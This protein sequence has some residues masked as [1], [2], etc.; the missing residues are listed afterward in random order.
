MAK[1]LRDCLRLFVAVGAAALLGLLPHVGHAQ[2]FSWSLSADQSASQFNN[3]DAPP[4]TGLDSQGNFWY[5]YSDC[6]GHPHWH[7]CK[8]TSMDNLVEQYSFDTSAFARPNGDD[9]YWI[10][11]MWIDPDT[12]TWWAVAHVE[13]D[14]DKWGYNTGWKDHFR[15]IVL[16]SS[17]NHGQTWT[18]GGDIITPNPAA[19]ISATTY[20]N[21]T[22]YFGDGDLHLYIDSAHGYFYL[23]YMTK[24]LVKS[25]AAQSGNENIMVARAP[26]SGKMAAGTWTKWSGGS[27][28]QPGLGG[29]ESAVTVGDTF[30]VTWNPYLG[31]YLAI[32]NLAPGCFYT[33]PD[34]SAQVWTQDW[35]GGAQIFA[36][37]SGAN[38]ISWYNWTADCASTLSSMTTSNCFRLYSAQNDYNSVATKYMWVTLANTTYAPPLNNSHYYRIVD[39]SSGLA[40]SVSGGSSASGAQVVQAAPGTGYEQQWSFSYQGNGYYLIFNRKSGLALDV[41]APV[42]ARGSNIIQSTLNSSASNQQWALEPTENG[43][44]KLYNRKTRVIGLGAAAPMIY[45]EYFGAHDQ[46]FTF[47]QM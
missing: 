4:A 21:D 41:A 7:T 1:L 17:T 23:Y 42:L 43:F 32:D 35:W 10:S 38:A 16:T 9:E 8:G 37:T 46:E 39:N 44:T 3:T 14:Y 31:Q 29:A 6:S 26:I 28:S 12:Q 25:T 18:L 15:R 19:V 36:Q 2:M 22:F 34:L 30:A 47:V 27:W 33:C 11:S 5:V 13:F 45:D 24:W 20:P 40:L